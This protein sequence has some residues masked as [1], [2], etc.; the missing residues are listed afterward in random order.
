MAKVVK[1]MINFS[2]EFVCLIFLKPEGAESV[3]VVSGN[4]IFTTFER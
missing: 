2:C 3:E 1:K 4:R